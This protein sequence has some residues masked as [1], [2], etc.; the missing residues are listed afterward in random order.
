MCWLSLAAERYEQT[1][2]GRSFPFQFATGVVVGFGRG[3]FGELLKINVGQEFGFY[4]VNGLPEGFD[5]LIEVFFVEK[6]LVLFVGEAIA[7][8]VP[9][10]LGNGQKIVVG[11]GGLHVKKYVRLPALTRLG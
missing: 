5:E 4:V 6:Q 9:P 7:L 11:A 10:A 2:L 3:A 8:Q 1:S